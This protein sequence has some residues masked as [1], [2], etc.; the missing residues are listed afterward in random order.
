MKNYMIQ[1]F[2][3]ILLMSVVHSK[4]SLKAMFPLKEFLKARQRLQGIAYHTPL[5]YMQGLSEKYDCNIYV[6]REDL[7][8]VRSYKIRGA[9][10]KMSTT[11]KELLDKGVVAASAGN[12]AQGVALSC[13][14]LGVHCKIFMPVTT[15]QQKISKVRNFGKS[16]VDIILIGENFDQAFKAAEDYLKESGSTFVHTFNDVKV[17]TGQ[18]TTALEIL[19]DIDL[20]IDYIFGAIG[21]GGFLSGVSAVMKQYSPETKIVGVEPS[22]AASMYASFKANKIVALETMDPFVDG[23]AI[24]KPGENT[25]KVLKESLEE[26]LVVPEGKVCTTILELYND[27][28]IVAEPAGALSIAALDYYREKIRGKTV[29]VVISGGNNDINRAEEIKRRSKEYEALRIQEGRDF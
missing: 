18:G 27:E 23:A 29:V 20:P 12:H 7:Q 10:N 15:P 8:I 1:T 14:K 26:I 28:G 2:Y 19:D 13:Q 21:G 24:G 22:G 9:Y 6:K 17:I 25:F 4:F 16:W 5:Q 3:V 11:S